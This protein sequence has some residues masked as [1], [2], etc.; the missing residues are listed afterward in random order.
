L[1]T[2]AEYYTLEDLL[3]YFNKKDVEDLGIYLKIVRGL[4]REMF[5]KRALINKINDLV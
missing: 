4:G 2:V 3:Y 5:M 1:E